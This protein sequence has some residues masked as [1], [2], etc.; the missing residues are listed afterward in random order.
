MNYIIIPVTYIH[1]CVAYRRD[2]C[3]RRQYPVTG[4]TTSA[5]DSLCYGQDNIQCPLYSH[6][7][8]LRCSQTTITNTWYNI[9]YKYT[10]IYTNS[11]KYYLQYYAFKIIYVVLR[12][13]LNIHD[14]ICETLKHYLQIYDNIYK[15]LKILFT[16]LRI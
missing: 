12:L 10:I 11:S 3:N 5:R 4:P 7:D 15:F 16:I 8:N 2:A 13:H 14:T 6:K 9:I 1:K